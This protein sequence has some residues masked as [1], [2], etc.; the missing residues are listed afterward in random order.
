VPSRGGYAETMR[1]PRVAAKWEGAGVRLEI[2]EPTLDAVRA[3]AP[4]LS[5]FYNEPVN[6]ALMTNENAMST[7]DVIAQFEEMWS[8]GGRPFLM[9]IDGVVVGDCD[10][11]HI[12]QGDSEFAILVG[13]RAMQARGMGTRFATMA[14]VVAF[15]PL[16]LRRVYASIRPENA[17]SLRMFAKVGYEIDPSPSARRF[18][19]EPDDVCMSI[20]A[21]GFTSSHAAARSETTW[22]IAD[23]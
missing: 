23:C 5:A 19:E 18:A 7:A 13:P 22:S 6:R 15:G 14:L 11:R 16:A 21:A 3:V 2:V 20:D 4:A 10:F 1:R 8:D 12:E 17:G 9:S